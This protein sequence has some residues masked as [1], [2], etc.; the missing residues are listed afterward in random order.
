MLGYVPRSERIRGWGLALGL[1]LCASFSWAETAPRRVVSINLCTDQLAMMIAAPGQLVSVS[2]LAR[3]PLSSAMAQEAAAYPSNNGLAEE[4]YLLEPD[5]VLTGRY[6]AQATVNMLKRLGHDVAVFDIV[7]SLDQ[8]R[9]TILAMGQVLGQEARATDIADAF[10]AQLAALRSQSTSGPKAALYYANGYT[11]GSNTLATEILLLAGLGNAAAEAGYRH[12]GHLPLEHLAVLQP[13]VIITGQAYPGASR[14][15]D[16][17]VH[18]VVRDLQ[19]SRAASGST[20]PDWVCGTPHVLRAIQD[21]VALRTRI[22]AE[23]P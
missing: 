19:S 7:G 11:S 5:L 22:E 3:D 4:I 13:D 1:A 16:I 15:E 6:T 17:L 2:H 18:P 8:L 12:G 10:D 21:M 14:S 23:R 9:D 20:S